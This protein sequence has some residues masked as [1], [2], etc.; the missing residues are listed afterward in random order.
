MVFRVERVDL[1]ALSGPSFYG[2]LGS[3]EKFVDDALIEA[4]DHCA[5]FRPT[6]SLERTTSELCGGG[7]RL[8]DPFQ[9]S[10]PPEQQK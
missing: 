7:R 2:E 6:L 4:E 3:L 1:K 5:E 9:P 8:T 10:L